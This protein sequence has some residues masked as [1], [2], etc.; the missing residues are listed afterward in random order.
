MREEV[1]SHAAPGDPRESLDPAAGLTEEPLEKT[2]HIL[3][4]ATDDRRSDR[5]DSVGVDFAKQL[6]T[7]VEIDRIGHAV[8]HVLSAP[9]G[10]HAVGAEMDETR[11]RG[12][13]ELREAVREQRV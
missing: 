12:I 3:E 1:G 6:R 5:Q 2:R 9:A 10:E 7:S 4:L 13:A 8:L 11:A